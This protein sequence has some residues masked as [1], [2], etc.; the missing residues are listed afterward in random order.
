MGCIVRILQIIILILAYIGFQSLGG[1]KF[2]QDSF[3]DFTKPSEEK[4]TVSASKM[5]DVSRLSDDYVISKAFDVFGMKVIEAEYQKSPQTICLIDSKGLIKLTKEDFYDDKIAAI[6]ENL[7]SKF[8]YQA[9]RIEN[10][11]IIRSGSFV[12]MNKQKIPYIIFEADVIRG[13]SP[14]MFGMLGVT[15]GADG[16]NDIILSFTTTGKYNQIVTE[17]FFRQVNYNDI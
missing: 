7:L 10:L 3:N 13:N 8:A 14:K 17:N 4:T 1:M 5:L 6:L 15:E 16:E 2:V 11:K 12:A 9:I